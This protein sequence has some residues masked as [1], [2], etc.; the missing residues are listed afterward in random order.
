MS[1][2]LF[3]HSDRPDEYAASKTGASIAG[4]I[5]FLDFSRRLEVSRWLLFRN[6]WV[7][8][9]V[10]LLIP[11]IHEADKEGGYVVSLHRSEPYFNDV[12]ALWKK[13]H[14]SSRRTPISEQ[15]GLKVIGDFANNFPE[16]C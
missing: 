15:D 3:K 7:G 16:D 1:F 13:W 4:S 10:G 9:A 6:R 12:R 11:V 2:Q 5:F 14:P 8:F